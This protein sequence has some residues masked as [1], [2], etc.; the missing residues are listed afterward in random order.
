MIRDFI[1][2]LQKLEFFGVYACPLLRL[3]EMDQVADIFVQRK[4]ESPEVP[5]I[6]LDLY[7]YYFYGPR[8][9][10]SPNRVHRE[11]GLAFQDY[12]SPTLRAVASILIFSLLPKLEE[13]GCDFY[14]PNAALRRFLERAPLPAMFIV[15]ILQ[16]FSTMSSLRRANGGE[17][18]RSDRERLDKELVFL[19]YP[20]RNDGQLMQRRL[21]EVQARRWECL[22]CGISQPKTCFKSYVSPACGHCGLSTAVHYSSPFYSGDKHTIMSTW[23]SDGDFNLA[24]KRAQELVEIRRAIQCGGPLPQRSYVLGQGYYQPNLTDGDDEFPSAQADHPNANGR[25]TSDHFLQRQN[26][27][28]YEH[29][30]NAEDMVRH[31]WAFCFHVSKK[32]MRPDGTLIHPDWPDYAIERGAPYPYARPV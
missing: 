26:A 3:T 4:R 1:P 9:S 2:G 14:N 18:P 32:N 23:K 19:C 11:Y 15:R 21:L 10:R 30:L 17:L 8:Y 22:L 16:L 25:V 6:E 20:P 7:P 29:A 24:M 28:G 31:Y 12:G 13:L 27:L 5:D